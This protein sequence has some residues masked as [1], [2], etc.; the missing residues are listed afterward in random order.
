MRKKGKWINYEHPEISHH[1]M[2]RTT[3]ESTH[4]FHKIYFYISKCLACNSE[5]TLQLKITKTLQISIQIYIY[6]PILYVTSMTKNKN[7]SI[8][9]ILQH[10]RVFDIYS[11]I[12]TEKN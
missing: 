10:G 12:K 6:I 2:D 4:R 8:N 7:D 3:K 5:K 9:S 1:L 11:P